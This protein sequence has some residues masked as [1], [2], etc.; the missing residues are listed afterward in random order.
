MPCSAASQAAASIQIVAGVGH[1]LPH[2]NYD[3]LYFD[4]EGAAGIQNGFW[5]LILISENTFL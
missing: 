5:P 4:Y 1:V 2:T 3:L